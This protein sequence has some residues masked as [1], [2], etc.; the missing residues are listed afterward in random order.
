MIVMCCFKRDEVL[1]CLLQGDRGRIVIEIKMNLFYLVLTIVEYKSRSINNYLY[2]YFV[3]SLF[4]SYRI[5]VSTT[6]P[7]LPYLHA[8]LNGC[9]HAFRVE[10]KLA[11]EAT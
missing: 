9:L 4:L 5:S 10:E 3:F 2:C 11:L 6:L 7:V 1:V 8:L